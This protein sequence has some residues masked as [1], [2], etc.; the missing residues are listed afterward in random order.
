MKTMLLLAPLLAACSSVSTSYDFDPKADFSG[1]KHYGWIPPNPKAPAPRNPFARQ[2]IEDAVNAE[3]SKKGYT[4]GGQA[5]FLVAAHTGSQQRV[6]VTDYG[7]GYGYWGGG[8]VDVYQYEEGT[9]IIDVI[10]AKSKKLIWRGTA[11]AA[12]PMSP[13]PEETTKLINEAVGKM[14]KDFPPPPR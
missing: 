10:S 3:L 7:Y 4:L 11:T 9:L 8:R 13:S 14:M 5:D 6:R 2:R 1:L 12:V